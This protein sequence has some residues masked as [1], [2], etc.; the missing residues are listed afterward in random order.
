MR[1]R[2]RNKECFWA[3][4]KWTSRHPTVCEPDHQS[5]IRSSSQLS[6][7]RPVMSSSLVAVGLRYSALIVSNTLYLPR[8]WIS[9]PPVVSVFNA[10]ITPFPTTDSSS[11]NSSHYCKYA[12]KLLKMIWSITLNFRQSGVLTG[13]QTV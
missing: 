13:E 10:F 1:R 9:T 4:L 3:G 2:V 6:Q 5:S 12:A 8:L 11:L 7:A